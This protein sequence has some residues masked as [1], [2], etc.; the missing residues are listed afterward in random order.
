MAKLE[1]KNIKK[2]FLGTLEFDLQATGQRGFQNFV[3][4]PADKLCN[5][6]FTIQSD[7]RI[8]QY[9]SE[10]GEIKLSKSRPNGSYNIHLHLDKLT[11]E[12]LSESQR[13]ELN[14]ALQATAT[15]TGN[16]GI[17]INNSFASIA[18]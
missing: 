15:N 11:S 3:F 16:G 12:K 4:Y 18:A 1:I 13:I 14:A 5:N 17:I 8:G 9:N 7:K 10:T 6:L 2:C